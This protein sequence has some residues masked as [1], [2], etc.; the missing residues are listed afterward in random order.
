MIVATSDV[1]V[2]ISA[3]PAKAVQGSVGG[4]WEV[5]VGEEDSGANRVSKRMTPARAPF[6]VAIHDSERRLRPNGRRFS[7]TTEA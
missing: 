3:E 7:R 1:I 4:G 2:T 5:A 6:I